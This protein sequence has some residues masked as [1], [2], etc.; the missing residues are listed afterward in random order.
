MRN[1]EGCRK[2][3]ALLSIRPYISVTERGR[4]RDGGDK[5]ALT[6]HCSAGQNYDGLYSLSCGEM[7]PIYSV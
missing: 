1:T 7:Q 6:N 2:I 4:E 5:T 3:A